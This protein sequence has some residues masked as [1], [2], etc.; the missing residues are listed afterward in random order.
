MFD[1]PDDA[2]GVTG[3]RGKA[4]AVVIDDFSQSTDIAGDH[5][6]AGGHCLEGDDA[7]R[8]IEAG[9]DGCVDGAIEA[10]SGFAVDESQKFDRLSDLQ[11]VDERLHLFAVSAGHEQAQVGVVP[12]QRRERAQKYLH[13]LFGGDSPDKEEEFFAV[14]CVTGA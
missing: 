2:I 11:F 6:A 14:G 13:T 12:A 4:G 7:E 9:E 8:F 5:V 3:N 10:V 1:C